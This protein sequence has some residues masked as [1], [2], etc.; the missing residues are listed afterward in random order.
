MKFFFH[1][2]FWLKLQNEMSKDSWDIKSE[3]H[4]NILQNF[5]I[6]IY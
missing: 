4:D 1:F 3:L 5:G 2:Q 6:F